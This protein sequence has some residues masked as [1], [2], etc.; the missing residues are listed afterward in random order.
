MNV[1]STWAT[2]DTATNSI[3][4]TSMATPH[5]AGLVAYLISVEGNVTPAEMTAKIQDKSVK[6]V[7]TSIPDGTVNDLAHS[8]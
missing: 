7:L 5:V 1:I 8:A 3:S 6:D 4:G 2:S